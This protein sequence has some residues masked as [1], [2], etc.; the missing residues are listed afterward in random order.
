MVDDLVNDVKFDINL[1]F[2]F[3]LHRLTSEGILKKNVPTNSDVETRSFNL[4]VAPHAIFIF[5]K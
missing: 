3:F 1:F 4:D 2:F 5:P